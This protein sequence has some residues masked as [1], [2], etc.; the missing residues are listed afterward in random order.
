MKLEQEKWYPVVHPTSIEVKLAKVFN[1]WI[2][3]LKTIPEKDLPDVLRLFMVTAE[4]LIN[5]LTK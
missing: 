1:R 5:K 2:D 3:G 4:R